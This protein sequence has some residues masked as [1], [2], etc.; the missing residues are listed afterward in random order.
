MDNWGQQ[1][2]KI[3]AAAVAVGSVGTVV[4]QGV[5]MQSPVKRKKKVLV[6]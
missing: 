3:A 4:I 2:K 5:L 6:N 1:A